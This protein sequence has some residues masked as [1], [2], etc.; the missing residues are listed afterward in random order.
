MKEIF[1]DVYKFTDE[2]IHDY[3]KGCIFLLK[4]LWAGFL[5][6]TTPIWFLL[7]KI[8]RKLKRKI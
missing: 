4:I 1:K 5:F 8:Y 6:T 3:A 7:Y 2:L